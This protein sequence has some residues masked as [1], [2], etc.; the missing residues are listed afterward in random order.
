M[1]VTKCVCSMCVAGFFFLFKACFIVLRLS[2]GAVYF[3]DQVNFQIKQHER[4]NNHNIFFPSS[5]TIKEYY[6]ST[7]RMETFQE[8]HLAQHH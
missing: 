1:D 6:R 7:D 3:T 8:V 4:I 5:F 2:C